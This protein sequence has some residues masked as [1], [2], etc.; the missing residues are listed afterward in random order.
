MRR[1]I[2][3]V[4]CAFILAAAPAGAALANPTTSAPATCSLDCR[5]V[6]RY[7]GHAETFVVPPDVH[8]VTLTLSAGSGGAGHPDTAHLRPLPTAEGGAGGELDVVFAVVPE[9]TLSLTIGAQG[10]AGRDAAAGRTDG[11]VSFGGGGGSPFLGTGTDGSGGGATIVR[12]D[13]HVLAAAGGGGGGGYLSGGAGGVGGA[14]LSG[15]AGPSPL[16]GRGGTPTSPGRGGSM[17]EG[18]VPGE[19]GQGPTDTSPAVGVGATSPA[20]CP[21]GGGGG[22]VF[23][24]GSG[25]CNVRTLDYGGGGGGSGTLAHGVAVARRAQHRGDGAV[26]VVYSAERPVAAV[27]EHTLSRAL[28]AE[29]VGIVGAVAVLV[30][31]VL[32]RRRRSQ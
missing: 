2:G 16:G 4:T 32:R 30:A 10:A 11:P 19:S 5:I 14:G 9:Q 13:G 31:L 23:G 12:R 24:G 17:P 26:V 21:G 8:R 1:R 3:T 7:S 20:G 22:G 18:G 29:V 6:I 15:E 28:P 27:T 25:A